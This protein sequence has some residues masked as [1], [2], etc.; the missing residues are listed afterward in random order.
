LP[1]HSHRSPAAAERGT[2]Y[3]DADADPLFPLGHGETYTSFAYDDLRLADRTVP[4]DGTVVARVGVENTGDRPGEEV[5]QAY[6]RDVLASRVRPSKRLVGFERLALAPGERATVR[7]RFDV[8]GFGFVD[9]EGRRVV[10]PGE[11]RLFVGRSADDVRET[12][13]VAVEGSERRTP[14]APSFAATAVERDG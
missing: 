4:P 1:V 8:T 3:V 13:S 2:G 9:R 5:V 10:E 14:A 11:F 7:F 12:A 6:V